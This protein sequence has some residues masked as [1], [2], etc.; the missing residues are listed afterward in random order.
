[1]VSSVLTPILA[2]DR[3]RIGLAR[4]ISSS[5]LGKV[6][7]ERDD[8][9]FLAFR[10]FPVGPAMDRVDMEDDGKGS[11]LPKRTGTAMT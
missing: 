8:N 9:Q 3:I 5:S 1:M 7:M 10:R 4:F 6:F 2:L 11:E